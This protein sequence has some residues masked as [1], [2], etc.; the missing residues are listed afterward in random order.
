MQDNLNVNQPGL[1]YNNSMGAVDGQGDRFSGGNETIIEETN[2]AEESM[3][4]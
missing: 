4:Q 3:I 2:E 1:H